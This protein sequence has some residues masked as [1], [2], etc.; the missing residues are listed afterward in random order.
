MNQVPARIP[1]RN[2]A[3]N[4]EQNTGRTL[5]HIPAHYNIPAV[6]SCL[7]FKTKKKLVWAIFRLYAVL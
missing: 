3:R 7:S 4:M 1:A 6:N 5:V 2:L